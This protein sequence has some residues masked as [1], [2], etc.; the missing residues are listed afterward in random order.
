MRLFTFSN[1]LLNGE[2]Y[3]SQS[4]PPQI[5]HVPITFLNNIGHIHSH[6]HVTAGPKAGYTEPIS[7]KQ[8]IRNLY[9]T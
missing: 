7:V 3:K 4:Q 8:N 1:F 6:D 9:L 2:K 5:N